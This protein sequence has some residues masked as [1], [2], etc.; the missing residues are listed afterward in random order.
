MSTKQVSYELCS[1]VAELS[2][3]PSPSFPFF[4]STRHPVTTTYL[5]TYPM[6]TCSCFP[7]V[8]QGS[9]QPF[10]FLLFL[11]RINHLSPSLSS[12][13]SLHLCNIAMS[14]TAE[15]CSKRFKRQNINSQRQLH[16]GLIKEPTVIFFTHGVKSY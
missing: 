7:N 15:E 13:S 5:S 4:R 1:L 8:M 3:V 9:V 2:R 12:S 11:L 16:T 14:D 6:R 10:P